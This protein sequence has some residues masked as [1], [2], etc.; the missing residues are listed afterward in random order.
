MTAVI[1]VALFTYVVHSS[2]LVEFL[3]NL[4]YTV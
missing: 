2:R 1:F 3:S 4:F